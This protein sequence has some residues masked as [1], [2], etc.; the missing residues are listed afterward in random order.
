VPGTGL[1]R[2]VGMAWFLDQMCGDDA[3]DDA[4]HQASDLGPPGEQETEL[5][6]KTR[7]LLPQRLFGQD[8]IDQQ[9]RAF[10]RAPRPSARTV[11]PTL[12]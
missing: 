9:G 1:G 5:E 8:F 2:I 7:Y 12:A 3:V 10:S 11:T 6:W 4:K